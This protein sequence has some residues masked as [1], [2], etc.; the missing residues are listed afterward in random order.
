[1]EP[2]TSTNKHQLLNRRRGRVIYDGALSFLSDL[3]S[4]KCWGNQF[5]PEVVEMIALHMQA[6]LKE[7]AE[8]EDRAEE[9]EEHR[10]G[11]DPAQTTGVWNVIWIE[12]S[13]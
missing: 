1:M 2:A 6:L 12:L 3:E 13:L 8:L 5:P 9:W 4:Y 11:Y 10:R 7:K